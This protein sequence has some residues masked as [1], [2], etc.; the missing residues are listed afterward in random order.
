MGKAQTQKNA[1]KSHSKLSNRCFLTY[2]YFEGIIF[3]TC[4][5]THRL[6]DGIQLFL[7]Q[8]HSAILFFLS[9][10]GS[11]AFLVPLDKIFSRWFWGWRWFI[12]SQVS[13][14]PVFF[15][16]ISRKTSER[17]SLFSFLV[18]KLKMV[19]FNISSNTSD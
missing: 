12:R 5:F 13:K 11:K 2:R 10:L 4:Y 9:L 18:A 14:T 15:M 6:Q 3:P 1:S 8:G 19:T 16:V 7:G 17:K